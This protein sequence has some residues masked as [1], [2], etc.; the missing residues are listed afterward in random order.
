MSKIPSTRSHE[1][2]G[3]DHEH[4]DKISTTT[5]LF[6]LSAIAVLLYAI[7]P[8]L[9]PFV[10]SGLLAY[11]CTPFIDW[12][13]AR[14]R[15]PRALVAI[16]VFLILV[17][18]GVG[19]AYAG[20]PPLIVEIKRFLTD[21]DPMIS[22]IVRGA[23]G[24]EPVKLFGQQMDATQIA[25]ASAA[26]FRNWVESVNVLT[27]M[28][29]AAIGSAFGSFLTMILLFYFLVSGPRITEGLFWLVPPRQR[30]LIHGD[31][32]PRLDPVL[33]R[34]FVGVIAVVIFAAVASYI[35]LGIFLNL[36]HAPFLALLTGLLEAIPVVGPTAAA[37]IAGIVALQHATGFGLIIGYALYLTVLRLSIDQ[38]F[39]PLVLGTAARVHPVLII[40]CFLSGGILFGVV[41]V[42]MAVPVALI[43]KVTL[44]T[45]YDEP[46]EPTDAAKRKLAR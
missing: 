3:R 34:Y 11:I 36:P 17:L 21:L 42:I 6:V 26:G 20:V 1:A 40:F 22:G 8:V 32:W 4:V 30:P 16:G 41:G 15:M 19:I 27:F 5:T 43:V 9:L 13:R 18:I 35:G 7:Q 28:G 29:G 10:L 2:I 24:S 37:A 23:I 45:L 44:A 38:L 46:Q 14:S 25:E 39:G 31:I 33:R 12:L